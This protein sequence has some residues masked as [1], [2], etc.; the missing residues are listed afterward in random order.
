M[1]LEYEESAFREKN[2]YGFL[3][4]PHLE[5]N[6]LSVSASSPRGHL[7]IPH[8]L[9]AGG[10][11]L[12]DLICLHLNNSQMDKLFRPGSKQKGFKKLADQ[13]SR[14]IMHSVD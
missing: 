6:F 3:N 12:A 1:I 11:I 7:R 14:Q 4:A 2:L 9:L 5:G 13:Q 8:P 10:L